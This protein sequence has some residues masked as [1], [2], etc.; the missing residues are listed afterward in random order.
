MKDKIINQVVATAADIMDARMT[1]IDIHRS[2]KE[3]DSLK[4]GVVDA[5]Q[6]IAKLRRTLA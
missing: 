2:F 1:F 4:S 5:S 6:T 3:T